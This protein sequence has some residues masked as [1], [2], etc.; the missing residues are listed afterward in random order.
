VAGAPTRRE[1]K[2]VTVVFCDLVG[3]TARSES[4]DPEDVE[5]FLSP[6]HELVRAELERHGGTVEKFIGDAVMALFGAPVAH[7]DDPERAVRASLA[8]RDW[9][10]AE[11]GVQVRVAVTTGEALVRLDARPEAGEGMASGDVVNTAA[12]LQSAAPVNG[13]LADETTYRATRHVIEYGDAAPVEAKGKT[14]PIAVWEAAK[15]LSRFGVDVAHEAR[16]ELVGRDR[17]LAVLRDAFDRARHERTPQLVTLVGVPGLGK[18]RL[19]FELQGVVDADPELITWRQGRCL[20]YGDGVT[21]WALG[22]IV[23]AQA[24]VLEQDSPEE[25]GAKLA[26]SV[27]EVLAGTG[28]EAWVRSHLLALAG[29]GEETELGGDRRSEAFAAWRRYLEALADHRP[30]VLVF[31]DLHWADESLLDFVDELVDW[32]S[33]VPLLVVGTAR[34]ELLERRPN[35]GGG[36]L[37]ATTLALSPLSDE[38]T[39]ELIGRLLSRPLLAA[40]SQQALLDRAGGNPLYAEQ[41]VDLYLEQGSSEELPLPETLQGIIAARLDA[42]PGTEKSLLQDASVIGKVFWT[43]ALVGDDVAASLHSLERKGFVRRQRRSSLEGSAELSFAHALVRD[44]AYGQIARAE[45]ASKHRR[46]AEWIES[47]GRP[48]DHAEMLA[49]HWS[50]ALELVRASGGNDDVLTERTRRALRDAGDRAFSLNSFAV[51]AS[52]YEEALALWPEDHERPDLLFRYARSLHWAYDDRQI[53]ALEAA[54]DTLLEAGDAERAAEAEAFLSR[55]YWDRG[56]AGQVQ[57]HLARAAELAGDSV[58]PAAARILAFS[59]RIQ[60]IAGH[61]EEGLQTAE[62]ALAMADELALDELR[63]HALTTIGMA[64][65]DLDGDGLADMERALEIALSADSPVAAPIVN[66]LGVYSL[67]SGDFAR[68]AEFYAEAVRLA[69]RYGDRSSVRFV[70]ANV[71]W[72]NVMRGHWDRGLAGAETFIAECEAGSPHTNEGSV[73]NSRSIVR[74]GRGDREGA[75]ADRLRD[76]ELARAAGQPMGLAASLAGLAALHTRRGELDEARAL[77]AEVVPAV[78]ELGVTGWLTDLAAIARELGLHDELAAAVEATPTSGPRAH[79]RRLV[80]LMLDG[81]LREAADVFAGIGTPTREA[82]LRVAAGRRF[83]EQGLRH[84]GEVELEKALTFFRGVDATAYVAEIEAL[85][86]GSAQ[87]ESA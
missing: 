79:W 55:A 59:S 40:D 33:D 57:E 86:A 2:V 72:L 42:L 54:R 66:N 29:L 58:S 8:I 22:E 80:Q 65:N 60:E 76:V 83:L 46:V 13:V 67:I 47:L 9:A 23:K 48:D 39:A 18:S 28:D 37:N 24:G 50:S 10:L 36:K 26:R 68:A 27:D 61:P 20:A 87:S 56:D 19:V 78:R 85:L 35:W 4:L 77:G 34:P 64:R 75:L 41:F 73:R 38:H 62:R 21:L 43:D 12:R 25:V 6:Y 70:T 32:V 53:D 51:A 15:A 44:V 84:E 14:E 63:A 52:Q 3:F 45:R 69:E 7:E 82:D 49:Y 71:I 31:E 30:L 17:E 1:R 11:D 74:M 81:E 5:A 16:A